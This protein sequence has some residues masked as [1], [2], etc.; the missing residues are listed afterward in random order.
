MPKWYPNQEAADKAATAANAAKLADVVAEPLP[1]TPGG[2]MVG[3]AEAERAANPDPGPSAFL[4]SQADAVFQF[5]RGSGKS[6]GEMTE[7]DFYKV[8]VKLIARDTILSTELTV[9]LKDPTM[10]PHWFNAKAQNGASAQRALYR[11]YTPCTKEDIEFC[12]A[13]ATDSNGALVMGDLVLMK[14][15]KVVQFGQFY[16][17]NAEKAKYRVSQQLSRPF[18]ASV[19]GTDNG[20]LSNTPASPYVIE[21]KTGS[22]FVDATEARSLVFQK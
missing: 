11:G 15:P 17:D 21:S 20:S 14:I 4:D 18:G 13:T 9:Q 10:V 8:P 16:K 1:G 6:I 5:E 22:S 12:H 2:K 3:Y 19:P 7:A